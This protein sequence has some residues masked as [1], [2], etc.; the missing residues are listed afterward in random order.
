MQ[1]HPAI[2]AL[3]GA[4]ASQRP[5]IDSDQRI[6]ARSNLQPLRDAWLA[7]EAVQS[8]W[9]DLAAY[10][11]EQECEPETQLARL[12][13]DHRTARAFVDTLLDGMLAQLRVHPLGEAPFRHKVSQGLSTIQLLEAPGATLSLVAYEPLPNPQEPDTVLFSDREVREIVVSGAAC[14]RRYTQQGEGNIVSEPL[15]L[16]EGATLTLAPR[17]QA[18]H[19]LSV[20]RLLLVLQLTSEPV[21]PASTRLVDIESGE[22][23]RL[24]SGDKSAS[25]AVMALGVLGALREAGSMSVMEATALNLSEDSEVRWESMRQLLALEPKRGLEL[26]RT[27]SDRAGDPLADPAHALRKRLLESQPELRTLAEKKAA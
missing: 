8:L 14:A 25:Q 19:V 3:R 1:I 9:R 7:T 24:A 22:T 11:A 15:S 12:L 10:G 20:S 21:R 18:R 2:A 27:L 23:L 5:P 6:S 17:T 13:E 26:L 4:P 16:D